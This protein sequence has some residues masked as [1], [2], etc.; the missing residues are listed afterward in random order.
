MGLPERLRYSLF[1]ARIEN[2]KGSL[3]KQDVL[4][5]WQPKV[6]LQTSLKLC[7]CGLL[8]S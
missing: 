6:A 7:V 4:R 3:Y 5:L 1:G 8:S 2:R